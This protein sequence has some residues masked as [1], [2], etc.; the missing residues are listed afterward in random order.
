MIQTILL[1]LDLD[2]QDE[3][4]IKIFQKVLNL[5]IHRDPNKLL[6]HV[7]ICLSQCKSQIWNFPSKEKI[8]CLRQWI[9]IYFLGSINAPTLFIH[10]AI[11]SIITD[12]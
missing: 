3:G 6:K 2:F 12:I 10:V 9:S 4:P 7:K 11:L 5:L 8:I 1:V